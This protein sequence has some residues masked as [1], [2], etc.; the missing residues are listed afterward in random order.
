MAKKEIKLSERQPISLREAVNRLFDESF[1]DPFRSFSDLSLIEKES[2]F[3][4]TDIKE[5]SKAVK[6]IADMPGV[7]PENVEIEVDENYLTLKGKSE[8]EKEEKDEKV[9]RYERHYGE[10]QRSF[11]LP[12]KINP[13]KVTAEIKN[14]VLTIT[15]P[16]TGEDKK[17][18]IKIKVEK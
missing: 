7:N 16:K 6:V 10:F 13:A 5:T 4:K 15:L 3:P 12:V 18:K 14:G 9:Y 8:E 11:V 17:K 1:W 2:A